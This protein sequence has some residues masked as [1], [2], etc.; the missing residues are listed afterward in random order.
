MPPR[1]RKLSVVDNHLLLPSVRRTLD[2]VAKDS[3]TKEL[4]EGLR[5]LAEHYAEMIDEA[6]TVALDARHLIAEAEKDDGPEIAK[7]MLNALVK[8]S[9]GVSTLAELGPKLQAALES[10]GASPKARA[11]MTGKGGGTP[12]ATPG[13]S[14]LAER[15]AR[16]A[17]RSAGGTG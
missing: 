3:P 1:S 9:E 12:N 15:R 16:A 14:T 5:K 11:A 7:R 17:Q 4:D 6:R 8:Y 2:E 10:L 13:R